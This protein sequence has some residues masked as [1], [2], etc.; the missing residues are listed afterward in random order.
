[1]LED[2]VEREKTIDNVKKILCG[3]IRY[4]FVSELFVGCI[5]Q[6]PFEQVTRSGGAQKK[7]QKKLVWY[8]RLTPCIRLQVTNF[9]L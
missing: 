5:Q 6:C 2:K 9:V 1:L 4:R 3:G 8:Q 7:A